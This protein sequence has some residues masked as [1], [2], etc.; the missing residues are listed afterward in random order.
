M[1][2]SNDTTTR[3]TSRRRSHRA[4]AH[5][6]V[7][8]GHRVD[9]EARRRRFGPNHDAH[10]SPLSHADRRTAR[11]I[12]ALRDEVAALGGTVRLVVELPDLESQPARRRHRD[13][14]RSGR[15]RSRQPVLV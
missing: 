11:H 7:D 6:P 10:R 9:R 1:D 8:R 14:T 15:G 2:T 12:M 5:Q 13:H 4:E 3:A